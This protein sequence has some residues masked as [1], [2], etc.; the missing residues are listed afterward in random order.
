MNRIY[1]SE[2]HFKP[3]KITMT[4][5]LQKI[6]TLKNTIMKKIFLPVLLFL[7]YVNN[8]PTAFADIRLQ[9]VIGNHMVLQQK[10]MVKIW[11][12]CDPTEK[13]RSVQVGTL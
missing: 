10:S 7:I 9:A 1:Q 4:I 5:R 6:I 13:L 2:R 11:G 8:C 12:W 3:I